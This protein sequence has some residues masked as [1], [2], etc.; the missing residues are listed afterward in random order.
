MS[1]Q[2]ENI[3]KIRYI[4]HEYDYDGQWFCTHWCWDPA[5]ACDI[6]REI[7]TYGGE[8]EIKYRYVS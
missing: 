8:A 2:L 6:H 3:M 5:E 7:Y 1:P 4:I